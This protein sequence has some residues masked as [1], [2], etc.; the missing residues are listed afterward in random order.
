MYVRVFWRRVVAVIMLIILSISICHVGVYAKDDEY[1]HFL[2]GDSR[3]GGYVYGGGCNLAAYG[4][5]ITGISMLMAYA[6]EDLQDVN[7]WN[8]KVAAQKFSF[9]GGAI[10]WGS[11]T[12][13]D[14]TF[15][16]VGGGKQYEGGNLSAEESRKRVVDLVK[17]GYY[18]L[19]CTTGL[20]NALTHYSPI[21]GLDGDTP[22][23]WDVAG[24]GKAWSE[25]AGHGLTEII[26]YQSTKRKSTDAYKNKGGSS[27]GNK[28][29]SPSSNVSGNRAKDAAD[30]VKLLTEWELQGM[31]S[32]GD[33]LGNQ[34]AIYPGDYQ[35]L[36]VKE[37]T[38]VTAIKDTM[39]SSR[40]SLPEWLGRGIAGI[41]IGC[42]LYSL[43]LFLAL[44]FDYSNV[45]IEFSLLKMLT[46][47][48]Y[49]LVTSDYY[50]KGI[51]LGFEESHRVTNV[52]PKMCMIRVMIVALVGIALVSGVLQYVIV[53]GL[54]KIRGVS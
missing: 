51:R 19:I 10:Y 4:C 12:N 33:M 29:K 46:L 14:P 7:V 54:N 38:A 30:T 17:K 45:F 21:V 39:Q 41:G 11:T 24:G 15:T 18:V 43:L 5:A 3:W 47:G 2:Q 23:V 34:K 28:K 53:L 44:I 52:T 36:S 6:N 22:I 49:R 50:E 9:A 27:G 26:A 16:I 31:P 20:Y 13:A 32:Q 8:P 37:K 42:L 1:T 25:W 35:E 48:R 40:I